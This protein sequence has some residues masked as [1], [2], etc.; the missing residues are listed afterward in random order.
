V[1]L[2][3]MMN[4]EKDGLRFKSMSG[5]AQKFS[6]YGEITWPLNQ[7]IIGQAA[8]SGQAILASGE[9]VDNF[10]G[11]ARSTSQLCIPISLQD[12]VLGVISLELAAPDAFTHEDQEFATRLASHAVLAIQNARLFEEVKAANLAKTE[13]MGVASHELKIPMTS[14]KGYARMMEM[15]GGDT[16]SEQQKGFL[17]IITA[18]VD[19]MNRLVADLL[20]VSRIEAGR[21]ELEMGAVSVKDVIAEVL[22]S[23]DAQIKE[24]DLQLLTDIPLD[25]PTVWADYGRLVQIMTN[26]VSNAYKYTPE[27]GRIKVE[28]M[29]IHGGDEGQL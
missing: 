11:D 29:R 23:V 19:R 14:I 13:F 12:D 7:G 3:A 24:K 21:I 25:I 28:A 1:G 10:A 26:L 22:A 6:K 5:V 15:V 27:G 17:G 16:L 20:D 9:E 2:M 8:S 18:N 4:D